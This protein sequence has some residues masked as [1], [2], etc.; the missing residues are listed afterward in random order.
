MI[1]T[2]AAKDERAVLTI[3][4]VTYNA[5][6]YIETCLHSIDKN[7]NIPY[8]LLI[9]D[10]KSKDRTLD[11]INS[12][13]H[14]NPSVLSEP[15]RGIYD[16]MNKAVNLANGKWVLFL[17]ADDRIL[18]SA[19]QLFSK[20]QNERT[21]YYGNCINGEQ[22]FGGAFSTFKLAK[23]NL[24]HQAILYP[25]DILKKYP[26]NLKYPVFSDY[27][28]NIQCWGD[29]S[30]YKQYFPLDIAY[31]HMEGYSSTAEDLNFVND[32]PMLVLKYLGI[33]VYIKYRFRKF[34][35][36]RRSGSKFF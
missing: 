35:E 23:M 17:G 32:K 7:I 26:F 1:N 10:G 14:L 30:F 36:S 21:I 24:C 18:P 28:L 2:F 34:K 3:V 5:E 31:Y 8:E 25:L 19:N 12:F 16:A 15:D 20:L 6:K 33:L 22:R 4:V 27:L 11:I 29:N 9:I 13:R